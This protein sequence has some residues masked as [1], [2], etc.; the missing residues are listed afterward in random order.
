MSRCSSSGDF[1]AFLCGRNKR[2]KASDHVN[3][4]IQL[5]Q[6]PERN[7]QVCGLAEGK[8][9]VFLFLSS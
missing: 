3:T 1:Y 2:G 6:A 9:S 8:V 5:Q 7:A 4:V